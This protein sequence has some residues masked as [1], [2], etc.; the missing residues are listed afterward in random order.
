MGIARE[1]AA[2]L[3]GKI[4]HPDIDLR[5]TAVKIFDKTS[6]EIK[7][8][9]M[10]PRYSARL[11]TGIKVGKSPGWLQRRLL[12]IG[13]KP[14]NNIV[15]ITNYVMM[16]TGQPLHAFDFNRLGQNASWCEPPPLQ[17]LKRHLPHWMG[18]KGRSK[19]IP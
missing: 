7:N 3:G 11:I 19:T 5:K 2:L 17:M 14:I 1:V 15:D 10:C 6:V 8:P 18:N 12:S 9:E 4:K 16:E 13:L